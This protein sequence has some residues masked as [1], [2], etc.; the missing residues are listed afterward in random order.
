MR[1]RPSTSQSISTR[2]EEG[3]GGVVC[4]GM[5]TPASLHSLR[6]HLYQGAKRMRNGGGAGRQDTRTSGAAGRHP[7]RQEGRRRVRIQDA[8]TSMA[9]APGNSGKRAPGNSGRRAPGHAGGGGHQCTWRPVP[10]SRRAPSSQR[11]MRGM[12]RV[13]RVGWWLDGREAVCA[14]ERLGVVQWGKIGRGV[15]REDW[16]WP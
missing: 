13:R 4:R 1:R 14:A 6:H 7:W 15:L 10:A 8:G 11:L 2:E 3:R 5:G 9:S 12:R 16:E